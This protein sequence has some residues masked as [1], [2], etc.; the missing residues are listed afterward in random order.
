MCFSRLTHAASAVDDQSI[1]MQPP[2]QIVPIGTPKA[3]H[4]RP[5]CLFSLTGSRVLTAAGIPF[6][7]TTVVAWWAA[8]TA[9]SAALVRYCGLSFRRDVVSPRRPIARIS[10][11]VRSCTISYHRT[12]SGSSEGAQIEGSSEPQCASVAGHNL[13]A[14]F[15]LSLSRLF[16]GRPTVR[17]PL[18]LPVRVQT[19]YSKPTEGT[20]YRKVQHYIGRLILPL[21]PRVPLAARRYSHPPISEILPTIG[22]QDRLDLLAEVRRFDGLAEEPDFSDYILAHSRPIREP[23]LFLL[24]ARAIRFRPHFLIPWR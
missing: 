4:P 24:F 18:V 23:A 13:P 7:S 15:Q 17:A 11:S 2:C 21:Q 16:F 19:T 22:R 10:G 14:S 1:N 8:W 20:V 9:V 6:S 12:A 3:V 5:R